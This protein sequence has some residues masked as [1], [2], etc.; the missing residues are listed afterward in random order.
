MSVIV[1]TTIEET[2]LLLT[3]KYYPNAVCTVLT[4]SH[5]EPEN[6]V[7]QSDIDI[8]VVSEDFSGVTS[9]TLRDG[10]YKLDFT[11][12]GLA[13]L[14]RTM[15]DH[16]YD[17]RGVVLHMMM[18][19][20]VLKDDDGIFP[21]IQHQA[22]ALYGE[23][24]SSREIEL[25]SLRNALLKLKKNIWKTATPQQ[26]FFM[27][28]E[29]ANVIT[30]A[31]VLVHE[32]WYPSSSFRRTKHLLSIDKNSKF[33][34]SI[35]ELVKDS[36][37]PSANHVPKVV[38]FIDKFLNAP[39]SQKSMIRRE[40]RLVINL[41]LKRRQYSR[42]KKS[43]YSAILEDQYLSKLF[44]YE[45]SHGYTYVFRYDMVCVFDMTHP[46]FSYNAVLDGLGRVAAVEGNSIVHTHIVSSEYILRQF[47]SFDTYAAIEKAIVRISL[48]TIRMIDGDEEYSRDKGMLVA[49]LLFVQLAK[50]L[51][52]GMKPFSDL[53]GYLYIKW[54]YSIEQ[55][56]NIDQKT[57]ER[58]NSRTRQMAETYFL[59]NA[60]VFRQ[61]FE[62]ASSAPEDVELEHW[63]FG[64]LQNLFDQIRPDDHVREKFNREDL[65]NK[66]LT[67]YIPESDRLVDY[68]Y[69][70][71]IAEWI[72]CVMQIRRSAHA[73]IAYGL[74]RVL[75]EKI[76]A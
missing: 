40:N 74:K 39:V 52:I 2:A 51:N 34:D 59:T 16:S 35:M 65:A 9:N 20:I 17:H 3:E 41:R 57:V 42:N 37:E 18:T 14:H 55:H 22:K 45:Q 13:D 5:T 76:G 70:S 15:I 68:H 32:G 58:I 46:E 73:V 44:L 47:L 7:P 62:V 1:T 63:D 72:L 10:M 64:Q 21:L 67:M 38:A 33:M 27:H 60:D 25:R 71:I 75:D 11:K 31:Y 12:V 24:N 69:F 61:T 49:Q 66:I 48:N 28:V 26:L 23:G 19:G 56:A 43:F 29:F 6:V 36:F 30:S 4:G 54:R 53:L 50:S 8:L